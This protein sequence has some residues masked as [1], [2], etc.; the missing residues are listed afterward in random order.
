MFANN[1]SDRRNLCV[2]G[3]VCGNSALA[4]P[5]SFC[6]VMGNALVSSG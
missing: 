3:R 4:Y 5:A 1:V 6:N 2:I